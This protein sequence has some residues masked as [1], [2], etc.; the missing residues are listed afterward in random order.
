MR[1]FFRAISI[2][3]LACASTAAA[4]ACNAKTTGGVNLAASPPAVAVTGAPD[5]AAS[6]QPPPS[7]DDAARG[8]AYAAIGCWIGGPYSEALGAIGDERT[9]ADSRRCRAVVTGP[10]GGKDDDEKAI[11]AVRA[12]DEGVVKKVHDALAAATKDAALVALLDASAA[13]TREAMM[14]RRAAEALRRDDLAKDAAKSAEELKTQTNALTARD[15][16]SKLASLQGA[17]ANEAQL[18]AL[19]LAADHVEAA[20]GLE[21]RAK[22]L[23]ASPGFDVAFS[24]PLPAGSMDAKPGDW[25]TYVTAAA[26][27][28]GHEV[29]IDAKATTHDREQAAFSGVAAGFA[30]KIEAIA[31]K[32]SDGEPKR[33]A[34][35]YANRLRAELDDA[36]TRAKVKADA[37][38]TTD[39]AAKKTK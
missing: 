26:K 36:A 37:T 22:I 24:A 7:S 12:M 10:L 14:A 31:G 9:L 6:A 5:P 33:V 2:A 34:T 17:Y 35:G 16:L 3:A 13:A 21:P 25:L 15:A 19:I 18:F 23:A 27:A 39:D 28:A 30:D 32:L 11:A 4:V 38:K 20:R 29:K 8:W 1:F